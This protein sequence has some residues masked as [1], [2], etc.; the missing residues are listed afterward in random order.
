MNPDH[1]RDIRSELL[2]D[3]RK[4]REHLSAQRKAVAL[5]LTP[6]SQLGPVYAGLGVSK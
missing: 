1:L 5:Y 4:T 3:E 2:E 6:R